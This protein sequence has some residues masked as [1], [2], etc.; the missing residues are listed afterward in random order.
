MRL[1][2]LTTGIAIILLA[3]F[4]MPG[5]A[6]AQ[7]KIGTVNLETVRDEAPEFKK[8]MDEIDDMV[9]EFE[10]RRDDQRRELEGLAEDLRDAQQRGLQ[11]SIERLQNE[12]QA[13][14]ADF[15]QFMQETFGTEGIIENKSSELL[16]PLYDKLARATEVVAEKLGLDLV[17]DLEVVNPLFVSDR[18]D[19]TDA[20]LD[21][22][23]K[24]W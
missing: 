7:V 4:V 22:F 9:E 24:T 8:A 12:L 14:S 11:G 20:V 21:E 19:I 18:L 2:A 1:H 6:I 13:K 5:G 16:T 15:Q 17:L 10:D 23:E 3:L